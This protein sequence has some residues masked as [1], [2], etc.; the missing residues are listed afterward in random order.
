MVYMT[1]YERS[2]YPS[3]APRFNGTAWISSAEQHRQYNEYNAENNP[4]T[5][6]RVRNEFKGRDKLTWTDF[7]ECL[8]II[9]ICLCV[10]GLCYYGLVQLKAACMAY[11]LK[12]P[13][14]FPQR[15]PH[16]YDR[17]LH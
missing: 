15:I 1:N 11:H 12:H 9:F 17:R 6:Y 7:W 16:H 8:F 14:L 2:R 4:R 10:I 13:E 5:N 3:S